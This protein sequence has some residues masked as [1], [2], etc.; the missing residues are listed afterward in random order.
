MQIGEMA[1][2][3]PILGWMDNSTAKGAPFLAPFARSGHD[4]ADTKGWAR[5]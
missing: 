5:L 2:S 4:A 3:S 1:H